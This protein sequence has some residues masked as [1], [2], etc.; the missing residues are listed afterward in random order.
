MEGLK[1]RPYQEEARDAVLR[2]WDA[3]HRR[4]LLVLPTGC[5]NGA[6]Q[7]LMADGT[8]KCA[9]DIVIGD[10]L[11]GDDGTPRNVL[12]LHTGTAE[13]MEVVPAKGDPFIVTHDHILSLVQ[14]NTNKDGKFP[15]ENKGGTV[16]FVTAADWC[17]K[18]K[19]Y[20]HIHKLYR[21]RLIPHFWREK[22]DLKVDPYFLGILIGDG[23]IINAI[24][25]TTPDEAIVDEIEK[26]AGKYHLNIRTEKAGKAKTYFLATSK[27]APKHSNLLKEQIKGLG[28]FGHN[29]Y[30]KFVPESYKT[31]DAQTRAEV[32]AGLLDTDGHLSGKGYDYVS[33][34]R[35]LAEDVVF[36]ARSLGLSAYVSECQKSCQDNFTGTYYRV[37]VS[38]HTELIPCRVKKAGERQ[39]KKDV[40]RTGIKEIRHVGPGKYY[41]FTVDGNNLYCMGDFTVTHNCGKTIVF[42]DLAKHEIMHG[43]H[44]L[45]LAHR[46]ELL[47]QAADKFERVTGLGCSREQAEETCLG[48]WYPVTVGSVQS[49]QRPKR[50]E[51]FAPNFFDTIIIDEAHHALSDGYQAVINHFPEARVLGVTATPDRGDRRNLGQFFDSLAY[52]YSMAAAIASGY[53]CPIKAQTVPLQLDIRGVAT[54]NGDFAA[55]SLGSALDPYLDKIAEEMT[56]YCKDRKTVVFL[57]LVATSQKFCQILNGIGFRAAEVNGNSPDR[58]EILRDFEAGK[59][60][61]LCNS[62]LLTEG[63][64]CPSVDC[65]INLRATKVRSLFQ[66]I[67]GRGT[68]LSPGKEYL[69][70]L[71]FLWQCEQHSLCRPACLVAKDEAVADKM[72]QNMEDG[73]MVDLMEAEEQAESDVVADREAALA[74][75]LA[76]MRKRKATLVD[77]LQFAMSIQSLDLA[78]YMPTFAAE[79]EP[80]KESQIEWLEKHGVF[81][82]EIESSGMADQLI[83]TMKDRMGRGLATP[84]QIRFLEKRG[85][86]HVGTWSFADANGMIGRISANGWKTPWDINPAT[87]TPESY[88]DTNEETERV[89]F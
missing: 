32:L 38:G 21:S 46:G 40:L 23:N 39:Q 30:T 45:I 19:Y 24:N 66:Q 7:I 60:N 26:Q 87:Y 88:N 13:M 67:V 89:S 12:A 55:G 59:Y 84:K 1:L 77:P 64:D 6:Q 33:A 78:N 56:R 14:T 5:H 34:S 65:I 63:W 43:R 62:M 42:C 50:L 44:V 61:V 81:G 57:P 58:E 74:E 8:L 4:T 53:L 51:K 72:A 73:Q 69:L 52:E 29:A 9:K 71:D 37:S 25:V 27:K 70:L 31:S 75:K 48:S 86:L 10:Q 16:D 35:Q 82:G 76:K 41:G 80:P 79:M 15:C 20:R 68:R 11:M 47:D 85:F 49:M 2:E 54:Q 83:S 3:G 18:P 17:N 22:E 28:L 36:L